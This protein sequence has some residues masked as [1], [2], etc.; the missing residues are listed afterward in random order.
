[1]NFSEI[2]FVF[3]ELCVLALARSELLVIKSVW[4]LINIRIN[5]GISTSIY[6]THSCNVPYISL[7]L[8]AKQ[9]PCY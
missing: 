8:K 1:M 6:V 4:I 2:N 5:F 7:L 9:C 3:I